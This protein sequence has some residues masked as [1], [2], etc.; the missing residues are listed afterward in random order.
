VG[1]ERRRS[2]ECAATGEMRRKPPFGRVPSQARNRGYGLLRL[3]LDMLL[4]YNIRLTDQLLKG[5]LIKCSESGGRLY[6]HPGD[7]GAPCVCRNWI[8]R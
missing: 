8:A 6:F 3:L 5:V 1:S 4:I 7:G 2:P